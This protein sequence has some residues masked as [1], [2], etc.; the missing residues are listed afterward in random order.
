MKPG[1]I[2]GF[3]QTI[4]DTGSRCAGAVA[5]I[6]IPLIAIAQET[7]SERW[8]QIRDCEDLIS[9][10][11]FLM[12][13]PD[14][15]HANDARNCLEGGRN[16]EPVEEDT[17][18]ENPL[19]AILQACRV[20]LAANRLTTGQGGTAFDCYNDVLS[21]DP[22]NQEARD[23]LRKIADRYAGWANSAVNACDKLDK[24]QS[25]LDRLVRVNSSDTRISGIRATL[26]D[27]REACRP[28][29]GGV[30]T[31]DEGANTGP[32]PVDE[33]ALQRRLR[34]VLGRGFYPTRK[35]ENG[36]TDLHFAAVL[37]LTG[38]ASA[39]LENGA[40]PVA[41]LNTGD[42]SFSDRLQNRLFALDAGEIGQWRLNGQTPLMVAAYANNRSV[43]ELLLTR[44]AS[45]RE[46]DSNRG[47]PLHYAAAG[48]ATDVIDL[49]VARGADVNA[50]GRL[51]RTPLHEGVRSPEVIAALVER[52]ANFEAGDEKKRKPIHYVAD[53]PGSMAVLLSSGAN[54]EGKDNKQRTP[55]HYAAMANSA[56]GASF[57]LDRG[58]FLHAK[59]YKRRTPLFF[60]A[61]DNGL[62]VAKV[63][64]AR[65]ASVHTTAFLGQTPLSIAKLKNFRKM[66]ELLNRYR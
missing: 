17:I 53:A 30:E 1:R 27:K 24:A 19:D 56:V 8:E 48:G 49:L 39:L 11:M 33:A 9:V 40:N 32:E 36:W 10:E 6:L 7:D 3:R 52:G 29:S 25:Y 13:Y 65:G 37:G 15:Q 50:V 20:H 4:L 35:D 22:D 41:Q 51:R 18:D 28:S 58:A 55:L 2:D 59:D 42:E 63:L 54:I 34:Q 45:V 57:L 61:K 12:E 47:T 64:L 38:F 44:G 16:G 60:A 31:A 5:V 66:M 14:S 62:E 43:A 23:G 21:E 46:R 26:A